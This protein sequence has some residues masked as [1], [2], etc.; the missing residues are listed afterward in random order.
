[1][2]SL[3]DRIVGALVTFIQGNIGWR[4][5]Q[6]GLFQEIGDV[7]VAAFVIDRTERKTLR[8]ESWRCELDIAIDVVVNP[9]TVD[10]ITHGGN[11]YRLLDER[12]ADVE[13]VLPFNDSDL[14]TKFGVVG[15]QDLNS[16]GHTKDPPD[17]ETGLITA[18]LIVTVRYAHDV[19]NPD[20]FGGIS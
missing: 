9:A 8:N 20:T 18:T 15:V 5:E 16:G 12:V 3:R 17:E 14:A 2:A 7:D 10:L 13:K 4:V 1:M 19:Q 11:A 6:R